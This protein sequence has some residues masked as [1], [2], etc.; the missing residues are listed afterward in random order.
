MYAAGFTKIYNI[1]IQ[2]TD[3]RLQLLYVIH[4]SPTQTFHKKLIHT[5]TRMHWLQPCT[6][7]YIPD[8]S[9]APWPNVGKKKLASNPNLFNVAR[10]KRGRGRFSACNIES[11]EWPGD[12][13]RKKLCI[14]VHIYTHIAWVARMKPIAT[15]KRQKHGERR[16]K[17]A[18]RWMN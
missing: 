9:P 7:T 18:D 12:E 4:V 10:E 1:I 2:N 14:H 11:W 17:H 5:A 8:P 13:A 16:K 3:Y 6:H 15:A